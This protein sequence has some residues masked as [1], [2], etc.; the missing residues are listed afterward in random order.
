MV[1]QKKFDKDVIEMF[2]RLERM[3]TG[4]SRSIG[5]QLLDKKDLVERSF[6]NVI[7]R[8]YKTLSP[9]ICVVCDPVILSRTTPPTSVIETFIINRTEV[10]ST[11]KN[12]KIHIPSARRDYSQE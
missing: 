5:A 7:I 8:T 2:D 12:K 9:V 6:E 1:N 4:G 3:F 10:V 11:S